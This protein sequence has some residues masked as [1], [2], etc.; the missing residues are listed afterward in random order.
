MLKSRPWVK[1][2]FGIRKLGQL[3]PATVHKEFRVLRRILNVA[4]TQGRLVRNPCKA[5]EFPVQLKGTTRKPHYMMASEQQRIEFAAPS[6]LRH[7]VIIMVETGLRPYREITPMLK[8]QVDLKNEVVHIPDSKTDGGVADMP[9]TPQAK[10]AFAE[11]MEEALESEYLFP[12]PR[13]GRR[14]HLT[15]LKKIWA[16]T[17]ERAGVAYFTLYELRHTFATRLSSG[18][19]P[20][21]SSASFFAKMT[22]LCSSVTLMRSST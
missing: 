12:S 3:K 11:Q 9:M 18:G 6:Y 7:V 15:T 2:K 17:L 13:P 5:V 1:T 14:P 21:T 8:S 22:R 19:W 4:M 10:Q 16:A 20:T